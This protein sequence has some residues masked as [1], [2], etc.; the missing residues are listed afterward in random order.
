M[1]VGLRTEAETN[2]E[3]SIQCKEVIHLL[4]SFF[5]LLFG[6]RIQTGSQEGLNILGSDRFYPLS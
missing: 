1:K 4:P 2:F 3:Y 5:Y 6:Q